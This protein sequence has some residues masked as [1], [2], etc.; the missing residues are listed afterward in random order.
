MRLKHFLAAFV[1]LVL[2]YFSANFVV[3]QSGSQI[4]GYY[5]SVDVGGN[6]IVINGCFDENRL[7]YLIFRAYNKYYGTSYGYIEKRCKKDSMKTGCYSN[8]REVAGPYVYYNNT[9][10]EEYYCDR[11]FINDYCKWKYYLHKTPP[12]YSNVNLYC[13]SD[14]DGVP[15]ICESFDKGYCGG[16]VIQN[17]ISGEVYCCPSGMTVSCD[18]SVYDCSTCE[19]IPAGTETPEG[20]DDLFSSIGHADIYSYSEKVFIDG[21][22]LVC[23]RQDTGSGGS[24]GSD[25]S[26]GDSGSPGSEGSVSGENCNTITDLSSVHVSLMDENEKKSKGIEGVENEVWV[27]CSA[28]DEHEGM[29]FDD[30]DVYVGFGEKRERCNQYRTFDIGSA[31]EKWFLCLDLGASAGDELEIECR[32]NY[33]RPDGSI[34]QCSASKKY[35]M[36]SD[37]T[38]SGPGESGP[39]E[40]GEGP[41]NSG[42]GETSPGLMIKSHVLSGSASEPFSGYVALIQAWHVPGWTGVSAPNLIESLDSVADKVKNRERLADF[43]GAISSP[44]YNGGYAG[45]GTT[46]IASIP[47]DSIYVAGLYYV[48]GG[49]LM[50]YVEPLWVPESTDSIEIAVDPSSSVEVSASGSYCISYLSDEQYSSWEMVPGDC[51]SDV[52]GSVQCDMVDMASGNL[53]SPSNMCLIPPS[54]SESPGDEDAGEEPVDTMIVFMNG[55]EPMDNIYVLGVGVGTDGWKDVDY[56]YSLASRIRRSALRSVPSD[57]RKDVYRVSKE[58]KARKKMWFYREFS[59]DGTIDVQ[60]FPGMNYIFY[61][62]SMEQNDPFSSEGKKYLGR[63]K[64]AMRAVIVNASDDLVYVD[65]SGSKPVYL[66][67]SG[68]GICR[69]SGWDVELEQG[70]CSSEGLACEYPFLDRSYEMCI[71]GIPDDVRD[72]LEEQKI[73]FMEGWNAFSL[74]VFNDNYTLPYVIENNCTKGGKY[75]NIFSAYAYNSSKGRFYRDVP[76]PYAGYFIK[77]SQACNVT[78][79]GTNM[80]QSFS[81]PD[82]SDAGFSMGRGW[83]L[84]S[85][86]VEVPPEEIL[87]AYGECS[88]YLGDNFK[89]D[90]MPL[91]LLRNESTGRYEYVR[92]EKLV[93]GKAYFVNLSASCVPGYLSSSNDN[94]VQP[95]GDTPPVPNIS[96]LVESSP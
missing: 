10:S 78:L 45:S 68:M 1:F 46:S 83:N 21:K 24:G 19:L 22:K 47:K 3:A 60:M 54:V 2:V 15:K 80:L 44:S 91:Y 48:R 84:F 55:E 72:R 90:A 36:P 25:K 85:V 17:R 5:Y 66:I 87:Q 43:V 71:P 40:G 75:L 95:P 31:T 32:A 51:P 30:A 41:G 52:S 11:S 27:S 28:L 35:V 56:S 65:V 58:M 61:V 96:G 50:A 79:A 33:T 14:N 53:F 39:G 93:P 4:S 86:P 9:G 59:S 8:E 82:V 38:G 81:N 18:D 62:Y 69:V 26:P 88:E 34:L 63:Q 73:E 57:H 37:N 23:K 67:S 92:A 42:D 16:A 77:L 29:P 20:Y 13:S 74:Y 70:F 49:K 76:R 12:E 64:I 89:E 7:D 6:K 94:S